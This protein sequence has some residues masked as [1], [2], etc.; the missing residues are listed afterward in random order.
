MYGKAGAIE[1][2]HYKRKKHFCGSSRSDSSVYDN[3][4][5]CSIY[6]LCIRRYSEYTCRGSYCYK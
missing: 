1:K 6:D 2:K 4:Y 3:Q 5:S